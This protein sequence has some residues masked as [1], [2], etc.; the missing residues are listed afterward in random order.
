ML[1]TAFYG[2]SKFSNRISQA[3]FG[4]IYDCSF[5]ELKHNIKVLIERDFTICKRS[6]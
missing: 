2:N 5:S 3:T 4:I 6:Y 1:G